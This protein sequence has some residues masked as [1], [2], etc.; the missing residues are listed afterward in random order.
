MTSNFAGS[1]Q[2]EL[3]PVKNPRDNRALNGFTIAT[4]D[5]AALS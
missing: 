3:L 4:F 5:D 2:I 1:I